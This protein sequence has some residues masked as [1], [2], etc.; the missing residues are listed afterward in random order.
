MATMKVY[1]DDPDDISCICGLVDPNIEGILLGYGRDDI[2][3][4]ENEMVSECEKPILLNTRDKIFNL[5]KEKIIKCLSKQEAG[6]GGD[7]A[8]E[9]VTHGETEVTKDFI[10]KWQMITRRAEHKIARDIIELLDFTLGN[11]VSF[12]SKLIKETSTNKGSLGDS[13]ETVNLT[14]RFNQDMENANEDIEIAVVGK[15]ANTELLSISITAPTKE[16]RTSVS[17]HADN[18]ATSEADVTNELPANEKGDTYATTDDAIQQQVTESPVQPSTLQIPK[19]YRAVK[20]CK[21]ADKPR[22]IVRDMACQ[23][24]DSKPVSREEFEYQT[25]YSERRIRSNE[26]NVKGIIKWKS[27]VND[28][29]AKIEKVHEREIIELRAMYR[30][31]SVEVASNTQKNRKTVV[32]PAPQRDVAKTPMIDKR[33]VETGTRA[34]DNDV[35]C[36]SVWDITDNQ[37]TPATTSQKKVSAPNVRKGVPDRS[38]REGPSRAQQGKGSQRPTQNKNQRQGGNGS[39]KAK[40]SDK[41]G[42]YV[43]DIEMVDESA[44]DVNMTSS[45]DSEGE[46]PE[47]KKRRRNVERAPATSKG[48]PKASASRVKQPSLTNRLRAIAESQSDNEVEMA[49]CDSSWAEMVEEPMNV[50]GNGNDEAEPP[51]KARARVGANGG[52]KKSAKPNTDG[53]ARG[54]KRGGPPQPGGKKKGEC[55]NDNVQ[56]DDT[57]D[58]QSH[59]NDDSYADKVS[60]YPWKPAKADKKRKELASRKKRSL[61]GV[62]SV[63][64][65]ELYIQGLDYEGFPNYTEMEELIHD[66]C[67]KRGVPLLFMKIIPTKFDKDQVGCKIAVREIDFETVMDDEFWPEYATVRE[68]VRK[69]RNGNGPYGH[70]GYGY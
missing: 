61:K 67:T 26:Q 27:L 44:S 14:Q 32:Q 55:L 31:L 65:R 70:D 20:A 66:Y 18:L 2:K 39:N 25:D 46:S 11:D 1:D 16:A 56:G 10:A 40:P 59:S 69:P 15:D 63:L 60:K 54:T 13:Q 48:G 52:D 8:T 37:S 45:S 47:Q 5:A 22:K 12:P 53:Q 68:W 42:A 17:K 36:E 6:K 29:F 58:G 9:Y 33:P 64:Q 23:T 57:D 51:T 4:I 62:K 50:D 28:R 19:G 49:E 43:V 35:G 21:C 24:D 41:Q 3:D 30:T 7:D 34:D 38:S